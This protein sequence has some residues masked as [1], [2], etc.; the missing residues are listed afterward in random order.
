MKIIKKK[1]K[2]IL[3]KF[4]VKKI[5]NII[6]YYVYLLINKFL[7]SHESILKV[8]EMK[9]RVNNKGTS[10]LWS[11]VNKTDFKRVKKFPIIGN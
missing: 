11:R 1:Y 9:W 5:K 2:T 7:D 3:L 8:V 6:Y 10:A 4:I